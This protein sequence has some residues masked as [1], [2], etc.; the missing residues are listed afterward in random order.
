MERCVF[1]QFAC[2]ERPTLKGRPREAAR[3]L[4][5][6]FRRNHGDRVRLFMSDPSWQTLIVATT[7]E[8][9]MPCRRGCEGG[10]DSASGALP[11]CSRPEPG[12]RSSFRPAERLTRSEIRRR[13][14]G[15][16]RKILVN[17]KIR[18][19]VTS[20]GLLLCLPDGLAGADAEFFCSSFLASISVPRLGFRRRQRDTAG[21]RDRESR[22]PMRKTVKIGVQNSAAHGASF[23]R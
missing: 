14:R 7:L 21:A 6:C 8:P 11:R 12:R 1:E 16:S 9:V 20:R 17:G 19:T 3:R 4:S 10:M 15:R 18:L 22:R 5:G 13:L 2:V 23:R